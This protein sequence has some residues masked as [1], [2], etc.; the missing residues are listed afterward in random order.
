METGIKG[1]RTVVVTDEMTAEHVGSGMLPVYATPE[2]I[3][4]V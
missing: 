3:A 4:L 2:M 1:T